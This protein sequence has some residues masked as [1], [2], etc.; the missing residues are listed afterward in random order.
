MITKITTM[1]TKILLF[2]LSVLLLSFVSMPIMGN[3]P[4]PTMVK[5]SDNKVPESLVGEVSSRE[6][7]SF[8]LYDY[9]Q[10]ENKYVLNVSGSFGN[11]TEEYF[12]TDTLHYHTPSGG[13]YYDEFV[14][15]QLDKRGRD[16]MI[17][18]TNNEGGSPSYNLKK[19]LSLKYLDDSPRITGKYTEILGFTDLGLATSE[20]LIIDNNGNATSLSI[21]NYDPASG[22][23]I[24]ISFD[25]I[26]ITYDVN[27]N[28]S[29]QTYFNYDSF[30]DLIIPTE[31][32]LYDRNGDT[33]ASIVVNSLNPDGSFDA[34]KYK[35]DNISS[36]EIPDPFEV[37]HKIDFGAEPWAN[38]ASH[39]RSDYV[40]DQWKPVYV[41]D[42]ITFDRFTVTTSRLEGNETV[43]WKRTREGNYHQRLYNKMKYILPRAQIE[44]FYLD[45][46]EE[47]Y[48]ADNAQWSQIFET[49]IAVSIG[50]NFDLEAG[51]KSATTGD[52]ILTLVKQTFDPGTGLWINNYKQEFVFRNLATNNR[53][54]A[55][56]RNN[57][58]IYPNPNSG[59]LNVRLRN[60]KG[61]SRI[62]IV[63][64]I[65]QTVFTNSFDNFSGNYLFTADL[66]HLNHGIYFVQVFSKN[67]MFSKKLILRQ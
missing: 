23:V 48:L 12:F 10:F 20:E 63:N 11:R 57:F 13:I 25:S 22:I 6:Y 35:I 16:T 9:D 54:E 65:G 28:I 58:T 67:E 36:V 26:Q 29:E 37:L 47:I 56:N 45:H 32:R 50:V 53:E 64:S 34:A 8:K 51:T 21:K 40:N 38:A 44:S 33:L 31:N 18:W 1:I 49:R 30:Q 17:S 19:R 15:H 52:S 43:P 7:L 2:T 62:S 5:N 4:Y 60:V 27:G 14:A 3:S 61:L 24:S 46:S 66:K 42:R 39:R 55:E 59:F 41:Q